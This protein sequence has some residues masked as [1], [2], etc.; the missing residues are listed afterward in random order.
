MQLCFISPDVRDLLNKDIKTHKVEPL[1]FKSEFS[2]VNEKLVEIL[3]SLIQINPF[4]R[5]TAFELLK[6]NIFD[7][8]RD[9]RNEYCPFEKLMMPIDQD[10]AYNYTTGKSDIYQIEDF[11]KMIELEVEANQKMT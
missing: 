10:E 3:E 6:N 2:H 9:K 5:P 4:F 1:D 7:Q 11:L 8:F